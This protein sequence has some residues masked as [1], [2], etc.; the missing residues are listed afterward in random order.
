MGKQWPLIEIGELVT[1]ID[2]NELVDSEREYGLLGMRSRIA[3][4]FLREIKRGGEISASSLNRVAEGDFIYS[5]LFAWQGSFGVVPAELD[6]RHVSNEFP[7][8]SVDAEKAS[9]RYL[10]YWFGLPSVHKMVEADCYGSTP[11]TRNRF[12]E[13][14]FLRLR[15]P[16]PPL[17]EQRRIVARL[18]RVERLVEAVY[19][20]KAR[21]SDETNALVSSLHFA[22]SPA[23]DGQMGGFLEL[24]EDRVPTEAGV[25]YPQV[26]VRGFAGGL[27]KKDAVTGA[28]TSYKHF[29]RLSDGLFLVSQPKGWEG[30]VAVC[31]AEYEG[32]F[33]SPEYR[34]FRCIPG[35]L[36]PD[37]L[38][39]LLSTPWFQTAL[40]K[41]TRGQ[42]ARRERLR[43]EMLLAMPIRMPPWEKQ[44]EVINILKHTKA[45]SASE[46]AFKANVDALVPAMLH[47][48]FGNG[49]A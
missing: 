26:G 48:I 5:R 30:A 23:A 7:I 33:A 28:E 25:A 41:L 2:R 13:V 31:G 21:I 34:T 18:D 12:K 35:K 6:G 22:F 44:L 49:E 46:A 1:Q 27:F 37:Y 10:V 43:P 45:I 16:L 42:G 32:W 15:V 36:H 11:G 14:Y 39:A 3:G 17:E 4:P 24:D 20:E 38:S 29:N 47:E 8:F 40:A 19:A 9:S